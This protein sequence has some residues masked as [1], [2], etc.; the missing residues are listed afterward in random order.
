MEN[1]KY[2]YP[3]KNIS[4]NERQTIALQAIR[5][6]QKITFLT[7]EKQVSRDFVYAQ[8]NKALQAI[9]NA[10]KLANDSKVLFYTSEHFII[11]WNEGI[12]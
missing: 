10:F 2:I 4:I 6:D 3:A 12:L 7:N 5:H 8:K 1:A 9:D 11:M